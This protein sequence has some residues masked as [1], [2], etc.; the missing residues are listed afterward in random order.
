M[1]GE[2]VA[3]YL[4]AGPSSD[5]EASTIIDCTGEAPV[6]LRLGAIAQEV[7]DAAL[8]PDDAEPQDAEPDDGESDEADA[9]SDD[10]DAGV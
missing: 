1:L 4:D 3:V 8:V 10:A 5:G 2:S 7:I 6:T 9:E